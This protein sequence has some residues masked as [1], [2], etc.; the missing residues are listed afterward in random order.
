MMSP[1]EKPL[2]ILLL[3]GTV[4]LVRDVPGGPY[5]RALLRQKLQGI[6]EALVIKRAVTPRSGLSLSRLATTV[7]GDKKTNTGTI[8]AEVSRLRRVLSVDNALP[9][10]GDSIWLDEKVVDS[11]WWRFLRQIGLGHRE[12]D[13]YAASRHF[14]EAERAFVES[15]R[16]TEDVCASALEAARRVRPRHLE[17]CALARW[18]NRGQILESLLRVG[19]VDRAQLEFL[20]YEERFEQDDFFGY[21]GARERLV[22]YGEISVKDRAGLTTIARRATRWRNA[23]VE[24]PGDAAASKKETIVRDKLEHTDPESRPEHGRRRTARLEWADVEHLRDLLLQRLVEVAEDFRPQV[25]AGIGRDGSVVA[26]ML[27]HALECRLQGWIAVSRYQ[28][29]PAGGHNSY[30]RE[31]ELPLVRASRV[32]LVDDLLFS[33]KSTLE[34]IERVRTA[35]PDARDG[36]V[37]AAL[38]NDSSH[39][40]RAHFGSVRT[41]AAIDYPI[42]EKELWVEF[43]WERSQLRS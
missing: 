8:R 30:L 16:I 21:G 15:Q 29:D 1:L 38:L 17:E 9:T 33:G 20:I 24:I 35:Y 42:T 39:P 32:L 18:D 31:A 34:A 10:R 43:P 12:D 7:W 3:H 36:L 26:T 40:E 13:P 6:L 37:V 23:T 14:H 5:R 25:V 2:E 19:H 4:A 11:D 27:G 28:H 22:E 41:V